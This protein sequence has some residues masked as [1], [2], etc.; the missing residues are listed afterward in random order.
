MK[1]RRSKAKEDDAVDE[2]HEEDAIV[3]DS[4]KGSDMKKQQ[5]LSSSPNVKNRTRKQRQEH[6]NQLKSKATGVGLVI[7]SNNS[8]TTKS[9]TTPGSEKRVN[10][11]IVFSEDD[12][13]DAVD[14]DVAANK[15]SLVDDDLNGGNDETSNGPNQVVDD[16]GD[17][18]DDDDDDAVEEMTSNVAKAKVMEQRAQERMEHR[19]VNIGRTKKRKATAE[20]S[21]ATAKKGNDMEDAGDEDQ[22]HDNDD[23]DDDDNDFFAQIDSIRQNDSKKEKQRGKSSK[24]T[25]FLLQHDTGEGDT[26]I[27]TLANPKL[28][29]QNVEIVVLPDASSNLTTSTATTTVSSTTSGGMVKATNTTASSLF[30]V[31]PTSNPTKDLLSS[32]MSNEILMYSRSQLSKGPRLETRNANTKKKQ[33]TSINDGPGVVWKRSKQMDF[34]SAGGRKQRGGFG[35]RRGMVAPNFANKSK[36]KKN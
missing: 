25:V 32:S 26:P 24:H 28:V 1:T 3:V 34:L 22:S 18:D 20:S 11:K 19:L 35:P 16:D 2:G 14:D 17:G 30:A 21:A 4:N 10:R 12:V 33:K 23:I 7:P 36:S 6:R 29:D 5:E 13:F 31:P 27:P 15:P 9:S 8:S